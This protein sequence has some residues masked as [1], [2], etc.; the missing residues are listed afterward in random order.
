MH[1]DGMSPCCSVAVLG[2]L[3]DYTLLQLAGCTQILGCGG[4][5]GRCGRW[6]EYQE[7]IAR[8]TGSGVALGIVVMVY[9]YLAR[10]M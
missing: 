4:G 9:L 10:S 8:G 2:T 5:T 1:V 3:L 6:D 7:V